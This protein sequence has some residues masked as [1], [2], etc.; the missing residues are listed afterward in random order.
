[1]AE[2]M[3]VDV[4]TIT[5]F[6]DNFK[7]YTGAAQ[8]AQRINAV[9]G[10]NIIDNPA[11]LV[12]TFYTTGAPGVAMLVKQKIMESG[13][14]IEAM[15]A[16]PAGAA[17]LAALSPIL[18]D[19]QGAG[20]FLRAQ[21]GAEDLADIGLGADAKDFDKNIGAIIPQSK[22][23]EALAENMAVTLLKKLGIGLGE[24]GVVMDALLK[25]LSMQFEAASKDA[26]E[27]KAFT[28]VKK[29]IADKVKDIFG[30]ALGETVQTTPPP[31]AKTNDFTKVIED[32]SDAADS[33]KI[34]AEALKRLVE[35]LEEEK[36]GTGGTEKPGD[37][38]SAGALGRGAEVVLTVDSSLR[39]GVIRVVNDAFRGKLS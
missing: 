13:I 15:L 34:S 28:E 16:G 37:S 33:L 29:T 31:E 24:T 30:V 9:F 2:K 4:G 27:G 11:E 18:G 39:S 32:T 19:P 25:D 14:D 20:R 36:A 3:K 12:R 10:M 6:A 23:I 22:Q 5:G 21:M 26:M 17:R 7:G 35:I 1:M 8:A 38:S